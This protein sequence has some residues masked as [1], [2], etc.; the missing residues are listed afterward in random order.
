MTSYMLGLGE[1]G[2]VGYLPKVSELHFI[3][4]ERGYIVDITRLSKVYGISNL[5]MDGNKWA[6]IYVYW[7][8]PD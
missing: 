6:E 3:Y 4:S 8:A 1:N 2:Q 5:K 7:E